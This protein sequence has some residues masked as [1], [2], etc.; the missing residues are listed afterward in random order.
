MAVDQSN[1]E[2]RTFELR[3]YMENVLLSLL[4]LTLG[5]ANYVSSKPGE[6]IEITM[7]LPFQ[8]GKP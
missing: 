7:R 2:R 5:G 4:T 8:D 6:G 3:G 1:E